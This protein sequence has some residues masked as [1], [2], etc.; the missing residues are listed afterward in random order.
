MDIHTKLIVEWLEQLIL[1]SKADT[2]IFN[3]QVMFIVI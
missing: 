1:D 3:T 2:H